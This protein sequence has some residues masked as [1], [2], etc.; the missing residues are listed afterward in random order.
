MT[1]KSTGKTDKVPMHETK[2]HKDIKAEEEAMNRH[3]VEVDLLT[4]FSPFSNEEDLLGEFD[5]LGETGTCIY[6]YS[7]CLNE[8]G[9]TELSIDYNEDQAR[10]CNTL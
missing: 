9:Q 3:D 4:K 8:Q 7:L 2:D 6:L 1:D 10:F 5:Q